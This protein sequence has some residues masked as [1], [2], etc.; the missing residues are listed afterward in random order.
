MAF[1]KNIL[2]R[3]GSVSKKEEIPDPE[4]L[5]QLEEELQKA[6]LEDDDDVK[7]S[8]KDKNDDD[9]GDNDSFASAHSFSEGTDATAITG[10]IL[11]RPEIR[12]RSCLFGCWLVVI[13]IFCD[14]TQVCAY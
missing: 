2:G 14:R 1:F 13:L 5:R 3:S 10:E 6:E 7:G 8:A 12:M 9:D 11:M 4:T